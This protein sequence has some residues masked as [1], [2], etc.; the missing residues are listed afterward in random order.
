MGHAGAWELELAVEDSKP[1]PQQMRMPG[2][3]L[4]GASWQGIQMQ[5]VVVGECVVSEHPVLHWGQGLL[6]VLVLQVEVALV[7]FQLWCRRAQKWLVVHDMPHVCWIQEEVLLDQDLYFVFVVDVIDFVVFVT[8]Y[9]WAC[10]FS[11][12]LVGNTDLNSRTIASSIAHSTPFQQL[13]NEWNER[14]RSAMRDLFPFPQQAESLL[15]TR[16]ASPLDASENE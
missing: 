15:N 11:T 3:F 14:G 9:S 1:G 8:A 13:S 16:L 6:L 4:E 2:W 10:F 7:Q 5:H 12:N